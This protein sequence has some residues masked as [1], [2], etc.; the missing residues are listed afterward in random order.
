VKEQAPY[1]PVVYRAYDGT[2]RLLY[3]GASV[4]LTKR[5][6][7]HRSIS[8]WWVLVDSIS[9]ERFSTIGEALAAE[10]EAIRTEQPAFNITA[11]G[12]RRYELTD[13]DVQACRQ[14]LLGREYMPTAYLPTW[15]RWIARG[16]SPA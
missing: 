2:G 9:T 7:T 4:R 12:K 8:W 10:T 16:L 15:M 6:A 3:V 1:N 14:W 5:L 11:T 13:S